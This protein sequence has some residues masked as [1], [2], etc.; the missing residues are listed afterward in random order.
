ANWHKGDAAMKP[1]FDGV[2][3]YLASH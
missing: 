2:A 1:S 3:D